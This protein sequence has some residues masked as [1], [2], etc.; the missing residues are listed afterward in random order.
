MRTT[1]TRNLIAVAPEGRQFQ[2]RRCA[3]ESV[4]RCGRTS[5]AAPANS[6]DIKEYRRVYS[7]KHLNNFL[8]RENTMDNTMKNTLRWTLAIGMA[9]I[10]CGCGP[11]KTP[12]TGFLSDYS[13]MQEGANSSLRYIN[14]DAL[15]EYTGFIVDP[16]AARFHAGTKAVKAKSEGQLSEQDI[17][18]LANYLHSAII[19]AISDAGYKIEY[20]S[21]PG[22]ARIRVAITDLEKT[23]V[24]LAAIPQA[25][26]LTGTGVGSAAMEA[27]IVDSMTGKQIAAIVE[28]RA[29]SRVP[30]T[31]L[32]DWGGAQSAIDEWAKLLRQR[33]DEAKSQR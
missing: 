24:A 23:N 15:G 8:E 12:Q 33:L 30:F 9:V 31:G 27:E 19:K 5:N 3:G 10:L 13:K 14:K 26:L 11:E 28:T 21:S 16:I 1:R 20:R 4:E 22:I 18:D 32:S 29:G 17:S 2:P 25:R 7:D 6:V